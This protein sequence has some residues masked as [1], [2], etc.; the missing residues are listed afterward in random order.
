MQ[1]KKLTSS[2]KLIVILAQCVTL[3]LRK[4]DL[5]TVIYNTPSY[6]G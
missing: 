6:S 4:E 5:N 3:K 2:L 1:A